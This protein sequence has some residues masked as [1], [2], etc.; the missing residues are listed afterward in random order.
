MIAICIIF[1]ISTDV[2]H[3]IEMNAFSSKLLF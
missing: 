3:D 2:L 1:E